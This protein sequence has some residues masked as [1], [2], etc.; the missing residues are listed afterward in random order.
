VLS[1]LVVWLFPVVPVVLV[2]VIAG[3]VVVFRVSVVVVVVESVVVVTAG[4]IGM[5]VCLVGIA[6][7][8]T[9]TICVGSYPMFA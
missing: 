6:W 5:I 8:T 1:V 3:F 9:F 4:V 2:Y 7:P